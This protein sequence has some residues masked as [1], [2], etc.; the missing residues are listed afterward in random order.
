MTTYNAIE[1]DI[2]KLEVKI[3]RRQKW[4][5]REIEKQDFDMAD[6]YKKDVS[7]LTDILIFIEDCDY[8]A[9]WA[10]IEWLDTAV[11]D[12]LPVRLY[13]FIAKENGYN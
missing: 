8:Q 3:A 11:R 5:E 7:D 13:N 12:D 10:I 4:Y 6:M 2:K 9:V 1:T